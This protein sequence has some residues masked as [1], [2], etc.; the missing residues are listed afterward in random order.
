MKNFILKTIAILLVLLTRILMCAIFIFSL[1]S[2][3]SL[4]VGNWGNLVSYVIIAIII[5]IFNMG[6]FLFTGMLLQGAEDEEH[7]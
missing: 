2:I 1:A 7:D 6:L 3:I 4:F 5:G